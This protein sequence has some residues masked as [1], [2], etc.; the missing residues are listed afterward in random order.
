M[1]TVQTAQTVCFACP[2]STAQEIMSTG[3][4][5]TGLFGN[6]QL[7]VQSKKC[8]DEALSKALVRNRH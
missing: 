5:P 3:T 8:T 2:L 7:K 4:I 1:T 6:Q